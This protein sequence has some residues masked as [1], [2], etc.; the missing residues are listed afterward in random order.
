ME[1]RRLRRKQTPQK[2]SCSAECNSSDIELSQEN[3]GTGQKIWRKSRT[4]KEES[5][6]RCSSTSDT[7]SGGFELKRLALIE[8]ERDDASSSTLATTEEC[9]EGSVPRLTNEIVD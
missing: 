1:L 7:Y 4:R 8:R 3:G 2:G 5:R 6:P 9:S